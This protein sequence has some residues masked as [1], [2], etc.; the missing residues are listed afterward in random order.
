MPVPF[1]TYT[2]TATDLSNIRTLYVLDDYR[3]ETN[4][5][6]ALSRFNMTMKRRFISDADLQTLM[7]NGLTDQQEELEDSWYEKY[8]ERIAKGD[9]EATA[10]AQADAQQLLVVYAMISAEVFTLM[11][12]D[13]TYRMAVL[14]EG[15][16]ASQVFAD[17]KDRV[18]EWREYCTSR[19]GKEGFITLNRY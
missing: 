10:S 8:N 9:D 15:P 5:E 16:T 6:T 19:E 17:M 13:A 18:I 7:N 1:Q 2:L 4:P 12:K 11:L 14:Q 3:A